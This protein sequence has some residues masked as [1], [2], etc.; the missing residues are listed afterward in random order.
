MNEHYKKFQEVN[1]SKDRNTKVLA[2]IEILK[3][4]GFSQADLVPQV[5]TFHQ[6][7]KIRAGF[8]PPTFLHLY[9][10]FDSYEY[11]RLDDCSEELSSLKSESH[12]KQY[13]ILMREA[14][15]VQDLL[16]AVEATNEN[17]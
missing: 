8:N 10:S 17:S 5:V 9:V 13:E 16:D 6:G 12:Q 15:W 7:W 14:V 1:L 2:A 3:K 11:V 4:N